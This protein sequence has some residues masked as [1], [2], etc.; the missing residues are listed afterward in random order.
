[1]HTVKSASICILSKGIVELI[2]DTA[3]TFLIRFDPVEPLQCYIALVVFD[4]LVVQ[5]VL[6]AIWNPVDD[7]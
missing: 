7:D 3:R 5:D 6:D 1:M 2:R 4:D